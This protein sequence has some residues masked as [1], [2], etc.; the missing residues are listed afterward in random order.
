MTLHP[1]VPDI[2]PEGYG[3]NK[4]INLLFDSQIF[5]TF[6]ECPRLM[7]YRFIDHLVPITGPSS[8][9]L[10]GTLAHKGLQAY[11]D[12][13]KNSGDYKLSVATA[14]NSARSLAPTMNIDAE[15]CLLVYRTLEEYF[16][17]RKND[18]LSVVDTE[19]I[20]KVIIYEQFPIRVIIT[21]RIDLLN[22]EFQTNQIIPW[23]HKTESQSW[24]Y[25]SLR[26]QFKFYAYACGTQRL[27]VNRIGF[28]TSLKPEKK[29]ARED[30]NFD[31]DIMDEFKNE[32]IPYY[33]KQLII[34]YEDNYFPPNYASCIHGN[35]GCLFSD[36]YNQGIC[37]VSRAVREDKL[38]RYF[39]T[40]EWDPSFEN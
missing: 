3:D 25:S 38:K 29:F 10:K 35:F 20:F 12:E 16:E 27:I 26:N 23:D 17:F 22:R 18:V 13:Y 4:W 11:Y 32:V 24:F 5:N 7:K 2:E 21:G 15:D 9:I 31:N 33:A 37:S 34:A 30:I 28:Q 19:R 8:S 40:E 1:T 39:K 6:M 14:L 36:K